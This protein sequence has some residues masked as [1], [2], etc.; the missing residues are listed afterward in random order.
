MSP[1][2]LFDRMMLD[3]VATLKSSLIIG[4]LIGLV[5]GLGTATLLDIFIFK[6]VLPRRV[7]KDHYEVIHLF[8]KIVASGLLL[9]WVTGLGFLAFYSY[10]DPDKLSNQ[11]VWAKLVV[12]GVLTLNGLF[13]HRAVLPL[14]HDHI[15]RPLFDGLSP[16]QRFLLLTS[17]AVSGTSWYVPFVLG[18]FPQFNFL[19]ALPLVLSYVFV[20]AATIVT[21]QIFALAVPPSESTPLSSHAEGAARNPLPPLARGNPAV[22]TSRA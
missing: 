13:I 8:S 21:T 19:P 11:K 6:F 16:G 22:A 10:F 15:G 18:A 9:L 7:S 1:Q 14:I 20:L 5:F 2:I 3:P 12:V 17:G 4:H